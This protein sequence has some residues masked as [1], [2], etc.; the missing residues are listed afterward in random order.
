MVFFNTK[1]YLEGDRMDFKKCCCAVFWGG[2]IVTLHI[3][4]NKD[5]ID[6]TINKIKPKLESTIENLKK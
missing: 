5:T 1:C 2:V 6:K 4:M 3:L